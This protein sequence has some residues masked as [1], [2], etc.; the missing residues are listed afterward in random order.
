MKIKLLALIAGGFISLSGFAQTTDLGGPISWKGKLNDQKQIPVLEMPGFDRQAIQAEDAVNDAAKDAPWRFGY[1]YETNISPQ[2][3]GY[4]RNLSNGD[5]LWRTAIKCEGAMTINLLME[6]FNLPE[7]SR[8]YLFDKNNTNRVGAYTSR[9][10]RPD[11]LLGTELVHGD[12]IIVEYFEPV[13]VTGQGSFTI[14]HVVHGY[15]SLD[16]IQSD[17][18][19]ALNSSGDCNIDVHCPLCNG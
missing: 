10:N 6:N 5:R 12:E 14:S 16:R 8:I 11:G 15:R 18:E 3:N 7:G 1:K 13:E 9:N 2:T 19:K 17:L 4:W